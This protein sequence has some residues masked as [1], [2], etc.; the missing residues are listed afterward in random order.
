MDRVAD[1]TSLRRSSD[2]NQAIE[3]VFERFPEDTPAEVMALADVD[4]RSSSSVEP[5][6]FDALFEDL[7]A[8][9][10]ADVSGDSA[11]EEEA[12]DVTADELFGE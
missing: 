11:G 6:A 5:A 4:D 9:G 2:E 8:V 7:S 12:F 1:G 3:D 10:P